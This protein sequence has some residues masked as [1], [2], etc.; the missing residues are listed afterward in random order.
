MITGILPIALKTGRYKRV[1][2]PVT[3]TFRSLRVEERLCNMCDLSETED[4][5]HFLFICPLYDTF[6]TTLFQTVTENNHIFLEL[7]NADNFF[8]FSYTFLETSV[9][10]C[11]G[12]MEREKI[13]IIPIMNYSCCFEIDIM[14][15]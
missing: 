12:C 3:K 6:R 14:H 11:G 4:E 7:N 8:I 1:R 5:I 10:I 9:K 13:E 15:L 2:E